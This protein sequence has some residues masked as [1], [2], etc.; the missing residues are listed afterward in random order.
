MFLLKID[1][2]YGSDGDSYCNILCS[3]SKELLE[4]KINSFKQQ[5][6]DYNNE[7]SNEIN[8]L[9]DSLDMNKIAYLQLSEETK[10]I[11]RAKIS[12]LQSILKQKHFPDK[13]A[14]KLSL[15]TINDLKCGEFVIE[16]I[17]LCGEVQ[18]E[19]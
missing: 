14:E 9:R 3:E 18:N 1:I 6:T 11:Y 5:I 16:E 2:N 15:L 13:L 19:G 10:I 8:I 17:E 12:E 4:S 7:L